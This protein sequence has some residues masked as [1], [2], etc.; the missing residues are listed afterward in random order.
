MRGLYRLFSVY[1]IWFPMWCAWPMLIFYE[2][3]EEYGH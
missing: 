1:E 3:Q 2:F